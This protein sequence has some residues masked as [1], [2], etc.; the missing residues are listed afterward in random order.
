MDWLWLFLLAVG[1]AA[2]MLFLSLLGKYKRQQETILQ[3]QWQ[4]QEYERRL[5]ANRQVSQSANARA[6]GQ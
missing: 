2:A 4:L 3:Q 5:Q 1:S 6:D